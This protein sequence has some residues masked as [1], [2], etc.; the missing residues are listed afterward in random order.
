MYSRLHL[1]GVSLMKTTILWGLAGLNALLLGM[2]LSHYVRENSA[3]A[4]AQLPAVA[5][6][7]G[8]YIICP[9]AVT[10]IASEVVYV[11]DTLNGQ[12]GAIS[13]DMN[14]NRLSM[15]P[16]VDLNRTFQAG[17]AAPGNAVPNAPGTSP[18]GPGQRRY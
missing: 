12:M 9:G 14:G 11:I 6:G 18:V 2:L 7:P 8:E 5:S 3:R 10:G 13:Y 4:Q 16:G 15:M 17:M 1:K